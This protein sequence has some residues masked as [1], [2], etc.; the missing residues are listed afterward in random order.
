[1]VGTDRPEGE[2]AMNAEEIKNLIAIHRLL[3]ASGCVKNSATTV[4]GESWMDSPERQFWFFQEEISRDD[5]IRAFIARK[6]IN[7]QG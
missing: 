7:D 6:Y 2:E 5:C 4:V 1:L 3:A